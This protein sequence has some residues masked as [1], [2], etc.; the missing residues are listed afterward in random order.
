MNTITDS[1]N[2]KLSNYA[3]KLVKSGEILELFEYAKPIWLGYEREKPPEGLY[4]PSDGRYRNKSMHRARTNLMR[5]IN[6]N[7]DQYFNTETGEVYPYSYFVATFKDNV[8]DLTEANY[9][10]KKF[11]QRLN[12]HVYG[13]K[14]AGLKYSNVPEF[15]ERGAIHYNI[16]FYNLPFVWI[17]EDAK[18]KNP[19]LRSEY[20]FTIAELWPHGSISIEAK[21]LYNVG[22]Y[23]TKVMGYMT[24]G[25]GDERLIGEKSHFSSRGLLKPQVINDPQEIAEIINAVPAA[26]YSYTKLYE[27]EYIGQVRYT[28]YNL[29][30]VK[31]TNEKLVMRSYLRHHDYYGHEK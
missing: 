4:L 31:I 18:K 16:I 21:K 5:S 15:Q 9:K 13:R 8:Q 3:K 28:Q 23:M 6:A 22:A 17:H 27:N 1:T 19:H 25:F 7:I 26:A 24:K 12:Y 30:S 20:D 11:I 2:R 14:C 10:A 29:R